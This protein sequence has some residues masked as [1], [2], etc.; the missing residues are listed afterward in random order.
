MLLELVLFLVHQPPGLNYNFTIKINGLST[1]YSLNMIITCVSMAKLLIV[2]RTGFRYS[3][4]GEM[5]QVELDRLGLNKRRKQQHE[6]TY[7]E[8]SD[9]Q[10]E[11]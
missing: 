5:S 4:W 11:Q 3:K 2:L 8:P 10:D 9:A 7:E 1:P 6:E